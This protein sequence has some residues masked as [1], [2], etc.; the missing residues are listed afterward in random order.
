[1]PD[2][3]NQFKGTND[4]QVPHASGKTCARGVSV[5]SALVISLGSPLICNVNI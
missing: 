4:S 2:E 3:E 5:F 1:M